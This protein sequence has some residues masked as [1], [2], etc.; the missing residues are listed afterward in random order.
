MEVRIRY[1]DNRLDVFDT[2]AFTEPEPFGDA[3]MLTDFE[4]RFDRLG[5]TG[6]W[7]VAHSYDASPAYRDQTA[8][9]DTPVARRKRGWRFLLAETGEVD[10]IESV[11]VGSEVA[12]QR[13]SGELVDMVRLDETAAA[14]LP[15][16]D[17][18]CAAEKAVGLFEVLMRATGGER[19]PEEVARMCGC[20]LALL[21]ELQAALGT[22]GDGDEEQEDEDWMEGLGDEVSG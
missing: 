3:N 20:S 7:L 17:G 8:E 18:M 1:R 5:D 21:M 6:L 4:L 9:G 22:E 10:R 12:L 2:D 16:A 13:M 19:T 11:A 15:G 14:W